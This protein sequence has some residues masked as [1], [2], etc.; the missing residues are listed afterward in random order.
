MIT[1]GG[2]YGTV[3]AIKN[4]WVLLQIAPKVEIKVAKA[5][6]HKFQSEEKEETVAKEVEAEQEAA[7]RDA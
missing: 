3:K 1:V 6:I 4:E 5:A 7:N 2:L